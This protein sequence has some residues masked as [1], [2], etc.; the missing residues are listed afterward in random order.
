MIMMTIIRNDGDVD[1]NQDNENVDDD[2]L[3]NE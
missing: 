3:F 1:H 2:K